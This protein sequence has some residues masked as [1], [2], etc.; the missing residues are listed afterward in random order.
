MI[1]YKYTTRAGMN[2][3]VKGASLLV[4]PL[5]EYNDPLEAVPAVSDDFVRFF[6][7]KRFQNSQ[8]LEQ[9]V[10]EATPME[11]AK[12]FQDLFSRSYGLVCLTQNPSNI[13]MWSYYAEEH[14]GYMFSIDTSLWKPDQV[15]PE[16]FSKVT[17]SDQRVPFP[18]DPQ[19]A[20]VSELKPIFM[21]KSCVWKYEEEYRILARVKSWKTCRM[22]SL[23]Y[24]SLNPNQIKWVCAGVITP[25]KDIEELC[26]VLK[27]SEFPNAQVYRAKFHKTEF[28]IEL[29]KECSLPT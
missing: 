27:T 23:D 11:L 3:I 7:N 15:T 12:S 21:T 29:P 16:W 14:N 8:S 9:L 24:L 10:A 17:Y 18:R 19:T 1:L 5:N 28:R 25:E 2:A 26:E 6:A 13:L 20:D 22:K 4:R